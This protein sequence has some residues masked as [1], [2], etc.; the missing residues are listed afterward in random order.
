MWKVSIEI[1][2]LVKISLYTILF[3]LIFLSRD[4]LQSIILSIVVVLLIIVSS[5]SRKYILKSILYM[6][7]MFILAFILWSV[8]YN[9]SL[10]HRYSGES[11]MYNVG[12]FMTLRLFLIICTSLLFISTVSPRELI[13]ALRSL[14]LPYKMVFTLG[15]TLRHISTFS[16]EYM[17][18]KEAQTSRGLE[19]DKGFLIKRIKSY[20]AVL[21]PLLIRSIENAEKLSLAMDL[22]LFSF[23]KKTFNVGGSLDKYNKLILII[24]LSAFLISLYFVWM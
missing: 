8:F 16:E 6:S 14:K 7:P 9:F 4:I 18:I 3:I 24:L 22:K 2:P 5:G 21:I 13:V 19:L 17:I 10:F 15:L 23:D 11:F 1:N 20:V 12:L